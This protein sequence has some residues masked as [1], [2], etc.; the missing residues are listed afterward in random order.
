MTWLDLLTIIICSAVAVIEATRGFTAALLDLIGVV[1]VLH[2]AGAVRPALG[3]TETAQTVSFLVVV[4]VGSG[5]VVACSTLIDKY[6]KWDIGPFDR[7]LAGLLGVGTGIALSHAAFDA[8]LLA[9]GSQHPAFAQ[10]LLRAEI[11]E[12]RTA[13]ALA[14]YLQHLGGGERVVDQ[15]KKQG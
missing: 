9:A 8:V 15:V 7:A 1:V 2:V 5:V 10:S 6:T 11:Y 3:A 14:Q 13:K 12:F 4:V